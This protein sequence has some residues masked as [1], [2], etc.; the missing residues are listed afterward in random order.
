[1]HGDGNVHTASARRR[2]PGRAGAG[3]V[4][5]DKVCGKGE[6]GGRCVAVCNLTR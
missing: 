1:M 2:L 3:S 6:R 5:G 4:G